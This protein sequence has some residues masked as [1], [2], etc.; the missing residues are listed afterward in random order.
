M[1]HLGE[2]LHHAVGRNG[3][4]PRGDDRRHAERCER[5]GDDQHDQAI[6]ESRCGKWKQPDIQHVDENAKQQTDGYLQENLD[7]RVAH[8]EKLGNHEY[9]IHDKRCRTEAQTLD[10][11]HQVRHRTH[12]RYTKPRACIHYNA[13]AQE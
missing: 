8:Q 13:A 10:D 12:G 5:Y 4:E 6:D 7:I 9:A 1:K 3:N 11:I 2:R